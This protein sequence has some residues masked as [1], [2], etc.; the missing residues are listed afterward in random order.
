MKDLKQCVI[1]QIKELFN[2]AHKPISK[3]TACCKLLALKT[4]A[5]DTQFALDINAELQRI[6]KEEFLEM[7]KGKLVSFLSYLLR[8]INSVANREA[9]IE[10]YNKEN[11]GEHF[12]VWLANRKEI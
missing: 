10:L 8:D 12:N 1:D 9:M 3:F 11:K 5:E 4:A 6:N 2:E 7:E